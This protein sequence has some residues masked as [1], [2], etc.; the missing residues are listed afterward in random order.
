MLNYLDRHRGHVRAAILCEDIRQEV[1]NKLILIGVFTGDIV[2]SE[3]PGAIALRI[4]IEYISDKVGEFDFQVIYT[5][6]EDEKAKVSGKITVHTP[7]GSI[8]MTVPPVLIEADEPGDLSVLFLI[9]G[10]EPEIILKKALT[11]G[12]VVS[13][14]SFSRPPEQSPP[15]VPG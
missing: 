15:A 11:L 9:E 3:F 2:L 8:G 6:N 12:E 4:Y 13:P 1:N 5:L 14:I 7:E 10:Q